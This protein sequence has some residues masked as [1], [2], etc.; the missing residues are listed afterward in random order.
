MRTFQAERRY[1]EGESEMG[2]VIPLKV[3]IK[4]ERKRGEGRIIRK[5][6]SKKLYLSFYY[7]GR[8]VE[9]TTGLDDTPTNKEI[10]EE[11]LDRFMAKV[12][13]GTFVFADAFPGASEKEKAIFAKLEGRAYS[14]GPTNVLF[15]DYTAKWRKTFVDGLDSLSKKRDYDGIIDYRLTPYFG[16]MTFDEISGVTLKTFI[17]SLVHEEGRKAGKKLS[18]SRIRNIL[19][20]LRAIWEDACEENHW[21]LFDP[22]KYLRRDRKILG[23]RPKSKPQVFRYQEWE[24]IIKS[25][26]PFYR[27]VAETMIMT[28]MIGSELAGLRKND[29]QGNQ[30]L[31]RNSIVR[32]HEKSELKTEYRERD[33]P[34]STLLC[35]HLTDASRNSKGNYV[36]TMKSGRTFDV[37]SFRKNP[38]TRALE[39]AGVSY[40]VPYTTRHS[41]AAW[42]LTVG[43]DHNRLVYLMGH[44]S[45]K[46]VYEVYGKYV[47]GLEK[48]A[49][50]IMAY[51]GKDFMGLSE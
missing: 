50:K 20:V 17:G 2:N 44:S 51:F 32:K 40:R 26:D 42:S 9:K 12:A 39:K 47:K 22:F 3:G 16:D 38:W 36:F 27:P 11:L 24:S 33:L 21:D 49:G 45:K 28:G 1:W 23:K 7:C 19:I 15:G 48:D 10:S 46:M 31:I 30:I 6:G 29:I 41:F 43:M 14:P 18:A 8:R 5:P 25:I 35:K 37:D 4:K 34:V 13:D